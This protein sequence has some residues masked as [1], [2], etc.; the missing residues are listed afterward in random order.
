MTQRYLSDWLENKTYYLLTVSKEHDMD[1][2]DQRISE[3]VELFVW[4]ESL[5]LSLDL[6]R[7]I[8]LRCYLLSVF[9]GIY[10]CFI[11]LLLVMNLPYMDIWY[12]QL[13]FMQELALTGL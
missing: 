4:L 2:P 7:K 9:C 6:A 10:Q 11:F 1:N 5:R 8:L 12:G 13:L 3:D